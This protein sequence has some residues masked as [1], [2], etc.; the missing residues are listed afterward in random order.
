MDMMYGHIETLVS[1]VGDQLATDRN[2]EAS[3]VFKMYEWSE[4]LLGIC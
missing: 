4:D 2:P 1:I 3:K